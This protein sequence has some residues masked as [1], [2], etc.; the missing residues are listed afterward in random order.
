[1]DLT[2][3]SSLPQT[4]EFSDY[5]S[6]K[7]LVFSCLPARRCASAVLAMALCLTFTSSRCCIKTAERIQLVYGVEVAL[8]L[9]YTVLEGNLGIC[10][11]RVLPSGT[12][13]QTLYLEKSAIA[14][15][16]LQVWST[17]RWMF[18]VINWRRSSIFVY[19]TVDVTQCIARVC[20]RQLRLVCDT[21]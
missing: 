19:N 4:A 18:S 21:W 14:R 16:P 8:G 2:E 15:R 20:L 11:V 9:S 17:Y 1:M 6:V 7:S 13:S 12:L 5:P 3:G 10:K